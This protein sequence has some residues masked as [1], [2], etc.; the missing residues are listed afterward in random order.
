MNTWQY[1]G[2]R[3]KV[4]FI[5]DDALE[6]Y[7]SSAETGANSGRE[8]FASLDLE[9]AKRGTIMAYEDEI[10]SITVTN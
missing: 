4:V 1:V 5:N 6:G 9:T 8:G 7:V 10:K 3:V 2:K